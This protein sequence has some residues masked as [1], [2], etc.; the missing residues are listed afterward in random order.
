MKKYLPLFI[1]II[2]AS[3]LELLSQYD[4]R[5]LPEYLNI[6]MANSDRAESRARKVF[7]KNFPPEAMNKYTGPDRIMADGI[8]IKNL[9]GGNNNQSETWIT[10]NPTNP[11]NLVAGAN[12]YRY[13]T[14]QSGYRMGAY[15]TFDGFKNWIHSATPDNNG[16][17]ISIPAGFDMLVFDPGITFDSRGWCYYS[18]GACQIDNQE[19]NYDNGLF[20]CRSK[21]GGKTWEEQVG[22]A[23]TMQG[24]LWQV[25]HDRYS[26]IADANSSSQY[27]DNIYITWKRFIQNVGICFSKSTDAGDN[28][29][30]PSLIPGG[31][32]NESQSPIPVVGPN[33][34]IYVVWRN[35][36]NSYEEV[37]FQKSTNGGTAW[38]ASPKKVQQVVPIGMVNSISHRDV[39]VKKGNM[40]V[41]SLPY[42]AVDLSNG[43]RKGYIYIVQ[44][45]KDEN[46][47]TRLYFAKSTNGGEDWES[48]IRIDDNQYA[49]DMFFPNISV[50]IG[51]L[52]QFSK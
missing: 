31:N 3:N 47:L 18:Y 5:Q 16:V 19:R 14:A 9:S 26:I 1:L 36:N 11:E 20:V 7:Y 52:L 24:T 44:T 23:L 34:E 40:R 22:V 41:S 51:C 12:D 49:N 37:L 48:K 35:P 38:L 33:G 42:I 50:D 27:K 15:A 45:G 32:T 28:W 21:D 2:L 25:F 29:S 4:A 6:N 8:E 13:L 39:L 17:P 10:Y 46:G 30:Q 43:P